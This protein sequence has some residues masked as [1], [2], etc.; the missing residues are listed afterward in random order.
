LLALDSSGASPAKV[1]EMI[2]IIMEGVLF[3][4]LL[5]T[6]AALLFYVLSRWTPLGLWLQQNRNRKRLERE[7][8]LVCPIHGAQREEELVRLPS[9]S[10][11]C[12]QCYKEALHE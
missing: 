9:G 4:A 6:M 11:I 7:W 12:P 1:E 10:R 2:G 5:A 8:E 3:V